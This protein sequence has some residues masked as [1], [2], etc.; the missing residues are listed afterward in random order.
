M[1][2]PSPVNLAASIRQRLANLSEA[3]GEDFQLTVVRYGLE[4]L[5]YRLSRSRESGDFTVKGAM[6]FA[7]WSEGSYRPTRDLDLMTKSSQSVEK[8]QNVFKGLCQL[9]VEPDGLTFIAD[10]V[11]AEPIR[12]DNAYGGIRVTL[13][14]RLGSMR[15][16]LQVDVGF[17]DVI[18]PAAKMQPFPSL[19]DQPPPML[20]MYPRE[21]VIAEKFEAI[22]KLGLNNSRMKD[23]YDVWVLAEQFEFDGQLLQ[24][25]IKATFRRRRT[26]LPLEAPDGLSD[27]FAHEKTKLNQWSA[28]LRRS[29]LTETIHVDFPSIVAAIRAF[30]LPVARSAAES[31]PFSHK[32]PTGGPWHS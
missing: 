10:T 27:G 30:L 25:A 29:R 28:F 11:K 18:T 31:N 12:E 9:S 6:V 3:R 26:E 32:W 4:R 13:L 20:A 14:G 21:S 17:G 7:V 23:Y 2:R 1:S 24:G 22:T 16:P 8:L 5:M 19:L 15:I